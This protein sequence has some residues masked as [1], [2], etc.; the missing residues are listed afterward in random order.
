MIVREI[1]EARMGDH[2][3]HAAGEFEPREAPTP[4]PTTG[5]RPPTA[6]PRSPQASP[7]P[8]PV[9]PADAPGTPSAT[10]TPTALPSALDHWQ[11]FGAGGQFQSQGPVRDGAA[12]VGQGQ[13]R[14]VG[15]ELRIDH[16]APA[17]PAV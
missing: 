15:E 2:Q 8:A 4:T 17:S 11:H 3:M 12:D 10:L 9:S 6:R 16:T 13:P 7:G 5:P 1:G 14:I